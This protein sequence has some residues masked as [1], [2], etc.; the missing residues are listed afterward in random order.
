MKGINWKAKS[1]SKDQASGQKPE[2]TVYSNLSSLK[3]KQS[4][5]GKKNGTKSVFWAMLLAWMV[6]YTLHASGTPW[7]FKEEGPKRVAAKMYRT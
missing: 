7:P 3:H 6:S 5:L 4:I 2:L 1:Y